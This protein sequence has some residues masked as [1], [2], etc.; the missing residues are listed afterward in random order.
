MLKLKRQN[1]G[2]KLLKMLKLKLPNLNIYLRKL[3][4]NLLLRNTLLI[5][6]T[7]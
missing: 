4:C 7:E 1:K 5:M 2:K 6:M 3:F